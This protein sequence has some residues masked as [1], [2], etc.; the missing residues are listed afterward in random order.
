MYVGALVYCT[1]V[2]GTMNLIAYDED[3]NLAH[4]SCSAG[5]IYEVPLTTLSRLEGE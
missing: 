1:L 2:A 3:S 4:V 5:L